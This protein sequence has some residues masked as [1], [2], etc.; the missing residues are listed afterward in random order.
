M[1]E[2]IS[3]IWLGVSVW[4]C[5]FLTSL[6]LIAV[7]EEKTM[8]E[9]WENSKTHSEL[10]ILVMF[11]IFSPM[12]TIILFPIL[13]LS[14]GLPQKRLKAWREK[15]KKEKTRELDELKERV[16]KLEKMIHESKGDK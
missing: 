12:I 4:I 2:A 14:K 8:K 15:R 5:M 11:S 7:D 9:V 1:I 16:A 10:H 13:M 3:Y 6:W